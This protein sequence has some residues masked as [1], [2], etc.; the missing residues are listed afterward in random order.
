VGTQSE[1][2][3][4]GE[5]EATD[6]GND[7]AAI[8]GWSKQY[9]QARSPADF[10]RLYDVPPGLFPA[11]YPIV[12]STV[13][14]Q[15]VRLGKAAYDVASFAIPIAVLTHAP[16]EHW[17]SFKGLL[18]SFMERFRQH[19]LIGNGRGVA[20]LSHFVEHRK[21]AACS[22][23]G[24]RQAGSDLF[25]GAVLSNSVIG[26][27]ALEQLTPEIPVP[28]D[29]E[30]HWL[31]GHVLGCVYHRAGDRAMSW[32]E[33]PALSADLAVL[34]RAHF[35]SLFCTEKIE[36]GMLMPLYSAIDTAVIWR[37]RHLGEMLR[38][39]G[40]RDCEIVFGAGRDMRRLTLSVYSKADY[41]NGLLASLDLA[42]MEAACTNALLETL[43]DAI[44]QSALG[45]GGQSRK[46]H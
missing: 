30:A 6:G 2:N 31:Y 45:F 35:S 12:R 40:A 29:G 7:Q 16:Q 14:Q 27:G 37:I 26:A 4:G 42:P 3:V 15:S 8:R 33:N 22:Y 13:Q 10:D 5:P 34:L 38:D 43:H 28:D 32:K 11:L 9:L 36:I 17:L 24:L 20:V 23:A 19:G 1:K 18:P 39:E 25:H 21:I 44:G 41:S 46:A